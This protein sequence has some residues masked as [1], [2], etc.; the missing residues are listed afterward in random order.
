MTLKLGGI[1]LVKQSKP[2]VVAV[3]DDDIRVRE[4]VSDLLASAGFETRLFSSAEAFMNDCDIELSC[5]L[6][7]DVRMPGMD[8]WELQRLAIQK[9]PKLPVVFITAH[10]DDEAAKRAMELGA[11]ALLYKPFDGE[12]LLKIVDDAINKYRLSETHSPRN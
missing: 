12:E 8:G 1:V 5:C 2:C 3:V 9:L 6:I 11:I 10:Q 4:S 7:T